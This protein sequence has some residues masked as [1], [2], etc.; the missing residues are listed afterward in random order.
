MLVAGSSDQNIYVYA[1]NGTGEFQHEY[2]LTD[3]AGKVRSV[4]LTPDKQWLLAIDESGSALVYKENPSTD[5]LELL[6]TLTPA[7]DSSGAYAGV[8]TDNHAGVSFGKLSGI[9][10]TFIFDGS[11]FILAG[12]VS[13]NATG[14]WSMSLT[15]DLGY[16]AVAV[17]SYIN[18]F[19][20]SDVGQPQ[21]E[22]FDRIVFSHS[23]FRNVK[24]NDDFMYLFVAN[25]AF[26]DSLVYSNNG[27]GFEP[28]SHIT[29]TVGFSYQDAVTSDLKY[30]VRC[31]QT[32]TFFYED[33]G[34]QND[35]QSL[36]GT[37]SDSCALS[38]DDELLI[39]GMIGEIQIFQRN[40]TCLDGSFYN[41]QE[42]SCDSCLEGCATCESSVVCTACESDYR[43]EDGQCSL[44]DAGECVL[45]GCSSC[46]SQSVC[47][48]CNSDYVLSD[49]FVCEKCVLA[50]CLKCNSCT[51]SD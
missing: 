15:S 1:L 31:T 2:T 39:V 42:W 41:S 28:M 46:F 40:R 23:D 12:Q 38:G 37:H 16:L 3:S 27:S 43:L 48:S 45:E 50:G 24:L 35:G 29:D 22:L 44:R 51:H 36:T 25:G 6:Q 7:G 4:D 10:Y 8:I 18:V 26:G 20:I 32:G 30:L 34:E 21:F 14:I 49:N 17:S 9:L 11:S 13:Q 33:L 5:R 19:T 47:R